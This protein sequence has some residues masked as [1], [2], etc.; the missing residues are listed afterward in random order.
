MS[1]INIFQISFEI[2]GC[3]ISSIICILL[4]TISFETKDVI[5]KKLWRMLLINNF[6]LV[7][8]ALAYI[9]R[10]DVT[11]IGIAMTRICNFSLFALEYMLL[12]IFVQ[13]VKYITTYDEVTS[14]TWWEYLAFI[15]QGVGFAGL[16]ITQFTGLYYS[17]DNT[18]HY[19]R[20]SGIWIS[21][22]VC[23]MGILVC[24]FRLWM[25]RKKLSKSVISTLFMCILIFCVCIVVQFVFYGL[26]LINIGLTI[27]LLLI[28]MRH[29]IIQYDAY[30]NHSIEE[31]I[32]DTEALFEWKSVSDGVAER[33][34]E[35][36]YEENKE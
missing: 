22:A 25:E 30:V 20:G 2:W 5:G 35:V 26:S 4:G 11:P 3:I 1:T 18:N 9:Y 31:A 8:D 33:K 28:Y 10:G 6:M 16:V 21:F 27:A 12:V 14:T 7:S 29:Y 15:L 19:Q 34:K 23:G 36:P 13:Y 17:F 24:I 32:K